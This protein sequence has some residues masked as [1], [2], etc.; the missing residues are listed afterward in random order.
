MLGEAV[1]APVSADKDRHCLATLR[2]YRS[3]VA[4][5][6]EVRR[7]MFLRGG[8]LPCRRRRL[9]CAPASPVPAGPCRVQLLE[10]GGV[11]LTAPHAPTT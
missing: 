2:P 1:G 8:A 6:E 10:L 11:A 9:S 3:L 5:A 7:P 4:L